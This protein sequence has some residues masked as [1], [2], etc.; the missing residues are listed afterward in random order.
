MAFLRAVSNGSAA[1]SL[2]TQGGDSATGEAGTPFNQ[3]PGQMFSLQDF[4]LY[5]GVEYAERARWS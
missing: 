2:P 1:I 5:P 3:Y 4:R